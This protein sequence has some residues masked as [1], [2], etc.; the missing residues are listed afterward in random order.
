MGERG[1]EML[2]VPLQ[3]LIGGV[4]TAL[5]ARRGDRLWLAAGKGA[6]VSVGVTT[7]L[8]VV[9]AVTAGTDW[10]AVLRINRGR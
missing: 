4:A 3:L 2:D 9:L 10:S 1:G 5:F 8:S 7:I 6:L